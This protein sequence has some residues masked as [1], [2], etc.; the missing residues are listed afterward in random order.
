MGKQTI[1]YSA[2]IASLAAL[3]FILALIFYRSVYFDVFLVW[4]QKN[5]ILFFVIISFLKFISVVYPP[6]PG[7]VFTLG[8]IPVLG[9]Q[10]AYLTDFLGGVGGAFASYYLSYKY[11]FR[12]IEK[13]FD[14]KTIE[15]VKKLKIRESRQIEAVI[16][17]RFVTGSIASEVL[18]YG[19][20]ILKIKFKYFFI[21]T[22]IAHPVFG[23]P[24]FYFAGSIIHGKNLLLMIALALFSIFVLYKIRGRY[25][26]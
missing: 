23:I 3:G 14:R 12:I 19:S 21:G 11:G 6:L 1:S 22:I 20:G 26:E 9:W 25:L 18:N 7:S 15:K 16:T 4:S 17:L 8:A 10:V 13:I 24:I 2:L 5:I